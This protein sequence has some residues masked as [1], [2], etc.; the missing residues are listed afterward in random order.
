M[1]LYQVHGNIHYM[2]CMNGCG[3]SLYPIPAELVLKARDDDLTDD[4][5][6]Q[7]QCPLCNSLARP[8]VLLWDEFYDEVLYR[9][10]SSIAAA[11]QSGLLVMAGTSGSSN[12]P[13]QVANAVLERGA[14]VVDINTQ[15]SALS[16][17]ALRTDGG[18]FWKGDSA[19]FLSRL[20]E[21]FKDQLS[22]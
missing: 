1:H 19:T 18:A 22:G 17:W 4:Q 14:T 2:R 3:D 8:H 7:L 13:N 16:M 6:Q 20:A 10:Y 5:W 15:S 9:Y 12:C 11:S 21:V